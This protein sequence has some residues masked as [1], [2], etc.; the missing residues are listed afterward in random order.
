MIGI[1]NVTANGKKAAGDYYYSRR[2]RDSRC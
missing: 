2:L 1:Q